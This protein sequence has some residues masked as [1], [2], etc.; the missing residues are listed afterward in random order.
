MCQ[1]W[2]NRGGRED[3]SEDRRATPKTTGDRTMT[4]KEIQSIKETLDILE[5]SYYDDL[6]P[7]SVDKEAEIAILKARLIELEAQK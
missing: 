6:L 7:N 3:M 4:Q 2:K 5:D 1:M